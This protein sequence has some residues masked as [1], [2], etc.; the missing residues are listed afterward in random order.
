MPYTEEQLAKLDQALRL[1]GEVITEMG[2]VSPKALQ[3]AW[4]ALYEEVGQDQT[5]NPLDTKH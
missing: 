1:V 5:D 3:S 4:E 2:D